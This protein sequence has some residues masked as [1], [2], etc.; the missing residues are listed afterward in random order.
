MLKL[1]FLFW[2]YG[3]VIMACQKL[4]DIFSTVSRE[5]LILTCC[6]C[7]SCSSV[8]KSTVNIHVVLKSRTPGPACLELHGRSATYSCGTWASDVPSASVS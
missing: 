6:C 5:L 1:T 4:P 8:K 3:I 7:F 2:C